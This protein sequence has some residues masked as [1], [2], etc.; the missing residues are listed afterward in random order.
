MQDAANNSQAMCES[1]LSLRESSGDGVGEGASG[2]RYFRGVQGD[3]GPSEI[4]R[5]LS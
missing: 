2:S 5:Y 1:R 4:G 3:L